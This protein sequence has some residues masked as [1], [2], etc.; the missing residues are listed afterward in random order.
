M[1][2]CAYYKLNKKEIEK[3]IEDMTKVRPEM[4]NEESLKLFNTIMKIIDERDKL[5][6]ERDYYKARYNEFIE[7]F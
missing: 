5:I 1:N 7:F 3:L 2:G 4:L 6:Q